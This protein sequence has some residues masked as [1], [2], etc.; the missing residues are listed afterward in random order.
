MKNRKINLKLVAVGALSL[1]ALSGCG[2]KKNMYYWGQY[3]RL[4]HDAYVKPGSADPATQIEK[5]TADI[6]Q[7]EAQGKRTPPGVYA[8]LGFLYATQGKDSQS[9]SAFMEERTLYPESEVFI[10]GMLNRA[11]QAEQEATP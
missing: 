6:Q 1:L 10:D 3:E 8:H 2:P 11:A 9:K 7:A 4:I 5:L